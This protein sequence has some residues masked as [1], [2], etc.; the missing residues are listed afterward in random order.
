MTRT[1]ALMTLIE[2]YNP[3]SHDEIKRATGWGDDIV[4]RATTRLQKFGVIRQC[5]TVGSNRKQYKPS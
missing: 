2:A 5:H 1:Q 3:V 4:R